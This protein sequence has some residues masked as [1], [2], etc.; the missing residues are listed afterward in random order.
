MKPHCLLARGTRLVVVG[1]SLSRYQ[2]LE[3]VYQMHGLSRDLA[4]KERNPL[5]ENTWPSWR[6]F[7]SGTNAELQPNERCDCFRADQPSSSRPTPGWSPDLLMENRHYEQKACNASVTYFF[8]YPHAMLFGHALPPQAW[9]PW[10]DRTTFSSIAPT[11]RAA[12][13]AAALRDHIL[14]TFRPTAL[15]LGRG[16]WVQERET[17]IFEMLGVALRA[18]REQPE[19]REHF[20]L[21]DKIEPPSLGHQRPALFPGSSNGTQPSL[22]PEHFTKVIFDAPKVI[23]TRLGRELNTSDYFDPPRCVH[24]TALSGVNRLLNQAFVELLE[25]CTTSTPLPP[26]PATVLTS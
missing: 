19:P 15:L 10:Q 8:A 4:R 23:S 14:P 24:F 3:L 12:S 5:Q 11:W 20:C 16:F 13:W 2:Y 22:Y 1:D 18:F 9:R 7:Y 26:S 25:S 6:A 17:P 21:L